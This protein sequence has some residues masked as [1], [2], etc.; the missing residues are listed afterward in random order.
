M[1]T[2]APAKLT[3]YSADFWP[4]V[5]G[6]QSVVML[7][8]RGFAARDH[9]WPVECTVVTETPAGTA[10][11][12]D[13]PFP[14]VRNPSLIALARLLWRSD[15]VHIAGPALRPLLLSLLMRKKVVVEHHGFQAICP[16]GLLFHEPTGTACPGHFVAGLHRQCWKCNSAAG[17]LRSVRLWAITFFR[18]WS[19]RFVA[20]NVAPTRW[21]ELL[22]QLPHTSLIAHGVAEPPASLIPRGSTPKFVFVGRLV[23]TKGIELL[24]RASRELS[25]KGLQF[26]LLI[27]GE[28]PERTRLE[29]LCDEFELG[30]RVEFTGQLADADVETLL[31]DALAIVMASVAG[32]VFGLVAAENMTRGRAVI[33]PDTGSLAEVVGE[34]GLK[35]AAGDAT[36]LAACMEQLLRSPQIAI[37][38]GARAR[39]RSLERYAVGQM[40]E[41]HRSLYAEVLAASPKH[42]AE[43]EALTGTRT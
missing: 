13:L 40:L 9:S 6:V 22:L 28:G 29:R 30:Q 10:S 15:L 33:V 1:V 36:S 31:C 17:Y 35:F 32:E 12:S 21:L 27:I 14:V 43:T 41:A 4:V 18:R 42:V 37:E 7:L 25:R 20:A 34:A 2:T 38:L 39:R 26:R 16:N 11:D 8:A 23:S 3:I 19:C 5:G 24:L